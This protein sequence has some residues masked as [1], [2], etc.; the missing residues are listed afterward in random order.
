MQCLRGFVGLDL[1][2]GRGG[3]AVVEAVEA[4]EAA[5]GRFRLAA[6]SVL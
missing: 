1:R 3:G 6:A 5:R 2:K 4:V